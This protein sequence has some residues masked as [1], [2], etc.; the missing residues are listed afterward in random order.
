[1]NSS[2]LAK[3]LR[4]VPLDQSSNLGNFSTGKEEIDGV[5]HHVSKILYREEKAVTHL[6]YLDNEFVSFCTLLADHVSATPTK[7]FPDGGH[8]TYYP[9]IQLYALGVHK[10]YQN[11]GIGKEI[12]KWIVGT[13]DLMREKV[14][15][16][17]IALE[18]FNDERLIRFYEQC[19]FD[20]WQYTA[21]TSDQLLPMVY[22]FRGLAGIL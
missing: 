4:E 2:Q 13:V 11:C 1:M 3:R 8:I 7:S 10:D 22:D 18:A 19:G 12:M 14:G 21:G 17:F 15:I 6:F 20:T 16:T 5:L 9:A